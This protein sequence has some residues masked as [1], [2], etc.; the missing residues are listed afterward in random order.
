MVV[1][2]S[3]AEINEDETRSTVL[4]GQR[5]KNIKNRVTANV[6]IGKDQWETK[7][8]LEKEKADKLARILNKLEQETDQWRCGVGVPK[9]EWITRDK[10][11]KLAQEDIKCVVRT[12]TWL[13][14]TLE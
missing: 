4:F 13:L 6:H 9:K 1:C 7:Y 11:A 3:P 12:I 14:I 8:T 5:V 2:V 10:Y